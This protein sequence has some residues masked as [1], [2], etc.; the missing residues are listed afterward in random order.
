MTPGGKTSPDS[1][2]DQ[3][4]PRQALGDFLLFYVLVFAAGCLETG[5][6]WRF[7]AP[8]GAPGFFGALAQHAA[9]AAL[10]FFAAPKGAGWL[11]RER[12]WGEVLALWTF[13][14]PGIGWLFIG[15]LRWEH[16]FSAPRMS[17]SPPEEEGDASS[18][19]DAGSGGLE[20]V[21]EDAI[22]IL[23]A[24]DALLG[25]DPALKRGAIDA[26]ARIKTPEAI[27]CLLSARRDSSAEVRF[28]ATSTLTR[29]K[30]DFERSLK[31][32][33]RQAYEKP[34]DTSASVALCRILYD[35]ANSG[36]MDAHSREE[37]LGRCRRWLGENAVDDDESL[38]L[39]YRV[40]RRLRHVESLANIDGLLKRR[41]QERLEWLKEKSD[42][43]FEL[44]RIVE[45]RETIEE[46]GREMRRSASESPDEKD[47]Q[48]A[49]LW[50]KRG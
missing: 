4:L 25:G 27:N 3:A 44:G 34:H 31:A 29:L 42:L 36:L 35:Y 18:A 23:P 9:A 15:L 7:I 43:L 11:D 49:V 37:T 22:D 10:M 8:S 26:L 16:G 48:A 50:W 47:W 28:F 17:W 32:A 33:E 40:N 21:Y 41:P 38:K 19:D 1:A 30:D 13:L 39:L 24:A 2:G 5:L 46:L 45:A 14:L 12:R 6:L 20:Q